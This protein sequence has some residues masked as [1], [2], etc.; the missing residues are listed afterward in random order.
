MRPKTRV[1]IVGPSPA[2]LGGQSLQAQRLLQCL[3]ETGRVDVGF[4]AIDPPLPG[5][6]RV[7]QNVKYLRTLVK[8][9]IYWLHLL[10]VVPRWQVL[11]IMSASYASFLLS[12]VPALVVGRMYG[13]KTVLNYRSGEADDHLSRSGLARAL[14]RRF[15]TIIVPS[16]YLADVFRRFG[17]DARAIPN[18][19]DFDRFRFRSRTPVRPVF[20]SNRSLD[21]LYNVG[22]I[23]DAY[24]LISH[25]YPNAS[26]HIAGDGSERVRL[27]ERAAALRLPNVVFHGK[28]APERMPELLDQC[29]IMLNSPNVDNMPSS[30][31]E[32]QACGLAVATTNVG[33]IPYIVTHE[34]TGLLVPSGDHEALAG[35]ALR[36]LDDQP[37][38]ER[39]VLR[40]YRAVQIC[41]SQDI[42]V[43]WLAVYESLAGQGAQVPAAASE[44]A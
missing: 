32:A 1:L 17:F 39:V 29:D 26:L 14:V 43:Q 38:A 31:L 20:L 6:L 11:H 2:I 30:I 16:D 19:V 22:C 13:K 18:I 34:E 40:A 42:G 25:R 28:V 3:R 37:F 10:V 7:L 9:L 21:P 4:L 27:Q 35:A 41:R 15:Q 44:R 5:P 12:P 24:S 36:Y 33:G 8:E 23:L